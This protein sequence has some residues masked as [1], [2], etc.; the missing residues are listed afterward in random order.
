ML[1]DDHRVL[2]AKGLFQQPLGVAR[3]GGQGDLD[4]GD[5]GEMGLEA[6]RVLGGVAAPAALLG[7]NDQRHLDLPAAHLAHLAGL[8][9]DRIGG[10]PGEIHEHELGHR[11]F[12]HHRQAHRR[13]DETALA[14]GRFAHALLAKAGHQALGHLEH[15]TVDAD[16]LAHEQHIRVA[17]HLLGQR[18]AQGLGIG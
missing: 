14:D 7:A 8:V 2:F 16:V 3:G 5:V 6:L 13:P 4:P 18:F 9:E 11:M 15:A 17:F 12:A 10:H 1:D